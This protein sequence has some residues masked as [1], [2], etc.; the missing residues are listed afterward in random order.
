LVLLLGNGCATSNLVKLAQGKTEQRYEGANEPQP[1]AYVL[2]PLSL[3]ADIATLPF[4]F[5]FAASGGWS[6][7]E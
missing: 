3:A 7:H 4:Q 6:G 5:T 1:F 2:L